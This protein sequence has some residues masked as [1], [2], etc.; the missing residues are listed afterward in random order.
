MK[1]ITD[2]LR[3]GAV[4]LGHAVRCVKSGQQ[5]QRYPTRAATRN[6]YVCS[7]RTQSEQKLRVHLVGAVIGLDRSHTRSKR[8]RSVTGLRTADRAQLCWASVELVFP[9]NATA[10]AEKSHLE[11]E[12]ENLVHQ[13][14]VDSGERRLLEDQLA[15]HDEREQMP[16][17][18][19]EIQVAH[20]IGIRRRGQQQLFQRLRLIVEPRDVRYTQPAFIDRRPVAELDLRCA[21]GGPATRRRRRRPGRRVIPLRGIRPD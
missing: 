21:A 11:R 20:L 9:C 18:K 19:H 17:D 2:Y 5:T 14:V 8:A 7:R 15:V 16:H 1:F 12:V 13:V 3:R 4:Y 10:W 6:I